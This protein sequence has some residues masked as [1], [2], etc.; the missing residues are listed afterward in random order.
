[1]Q[2]LSAGTSLYAKPKQ[3]L[4]DQGVLIKALICN[5]ILELEASGQ[6]AFQDRYTEQF[7][8]SRTK[9]NR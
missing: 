7:C 8:I 6:M 5:T 2:G 1:M 4:K 3:I 9:M